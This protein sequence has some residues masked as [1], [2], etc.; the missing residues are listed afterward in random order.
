LCGTVSASL[1]SGRQSRIKRPQKPTAGKNTTAVGS[2]EARDGPGECGLL[3]VDDQIVEPAKG[4]LRHT[5]IA[6]REQHYIKDVPEEAVRAVEKIDAL[7]TKD[8]GPVQ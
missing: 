1:I 6:T 3:F 5:N 8:A 7:F 2:A 4:L